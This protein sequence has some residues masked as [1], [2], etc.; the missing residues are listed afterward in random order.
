MI[1]RI[2]GQDGKEAEVKLPGHYVIGRIGNNV[3]LFKGGRDAMTTDEILQP[4]AELED[5]DDSVADNHLDVIVDAESLRLRD[6]NTLGGSFFYPY[7]NERARRFTGREIKVTP[8]KS[9]LVS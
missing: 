9:I 8:S 2:I 5:G 1:F 6:K 4:I 7:P 3:V